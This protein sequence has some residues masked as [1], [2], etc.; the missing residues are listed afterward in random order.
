[1]QWQQPDPRRLLEY[2]IVTAFSFQLLRCF[3]ILH[4]GWPGK[5]LAGNTIAACF[6]PAVQLMWQLMRQ[7]VEA[8][9]AVVTESSGNTSSSG[10]SSSSSSSSNPVA[11]VHP[12]V[13]SE[14]VNRLS[15]LADRTVTEFGEHILSGLSGMPQQS[16][17]LLAEPDLYRALAAALGEGFGSH[18]HQQTRPCSPAT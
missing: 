17:E 11:A 4:L 6:R 9:T 14:A 8:P 3:D 5:L 15:R 1:M 13:W 7:G 12:R 2:E 16:V 10:A 18:R